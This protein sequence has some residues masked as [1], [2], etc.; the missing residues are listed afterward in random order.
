MGQILIVVR[1]DAGINGYGV[2]GGG[3][4]GRHV[5]NSVLRDL[6]LGRDAEQTSQ[7]YDE[8]YQAT[9]P[10]GR[11]GLAVM[12]L[13][14]VDLA[15]WDIRGKAERKPVVSLLGGQ[16]GTPIPAYRTVWDTVPPEL[17]GQFSAYKLHL[18]QTPLENLLSRIESARKAIGPDCE[19]MTDAWMKWDLPTTLAFA[20]EAEPYQLGWIEEPLPIDDREG[21]ETLRNECPIPIAGGE[22]EFTEYGFG[23]VIRNRLHS[24]LQPDVCWCG[25][26][27][28]LV[29]I[30][31]QALKAGIRICPHRGAEI[32]GLHAIA[33]LDPHP[34]AESGRPWMTWVLGQPSIRQGTV[35]LE[36]EPGFGIT[37]DETTPLLR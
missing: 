24:V 3:L 17:V 2:G 13:S 25:G 27:T 21:Y 5:V 16:P 33:A 8:M 9:V 28:A 31:E 35:T 19:L 29:R 22:H 14:G 10:F 4:A 6:L 36:D 23:D 30:Y 26:M 15:L 12:A 20:R 32:W 37:I 1:T 34:L 18:G 7:L 11:K